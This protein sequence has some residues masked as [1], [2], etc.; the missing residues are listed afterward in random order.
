MGHP[1]LHS[2]SVRISHLALLTAFGLLLFLF[3]SYIPRPMPWVK[4][5]LGNLATLMGLYL[6]GAPAAM[7]ITLLRV[8]LGSLLI[9]SFTN[10]TFL[11]SLFGGVA[12][13]LAMAITL[14]VSGKIFSVVGISLIGSV[15][16]NLAQ[17]IGG[18][19]LVVK[20]PQIFY[21][22]PLM[23]FPALVTG[24]LVGLLGLL[25]LNQ[26]QR[27]GKNLRWLSPLHRKRAA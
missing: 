13:T 10:P 4:P 12:A 21:L 22:L 3:E 11:L 8:T 9:G 7:T 19:L 20:N 18:Y 1:I 25:V 14:K 16:H 26:L 24:L 27:I 2:H 15:T 6:F 5:G 17:I 23:L